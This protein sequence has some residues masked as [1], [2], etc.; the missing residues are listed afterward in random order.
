MGSVEQM[1]R[2]G[3]AHRDQHRQ[4]RLSTGQ[5]NQHRAAKPKIGVAVV[6]VLIVARRERVDQGTPEIGAEFYHA[7]PTLTASCHHGGYSCRCR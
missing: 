3:L 6:Q 1:Q 4:C 5:R 7:L 2:T